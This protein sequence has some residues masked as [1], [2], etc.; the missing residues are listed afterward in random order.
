[1]AAKHG[2]FN[3]TAITDSKLFKELECVG[4][5]NQM[6]EALDLDADPYLFEKMS[7]CYFPGAAVFKLANS[8][9]R[10]QAEVSAY[11]RKAQGEQAW[12]T[13]FNVRRNYSSPFRVDEGLE[14]WGMHHASVVN[15]VRTAKTALMEVFDR[16]T[17]AEWIEQKIYP[18]YKD[19]L[20]LGEKAQK[21][22]ARTTWPARPHEPLPELRALGVGLTDT[23]EAAVQEAAAKQRQQQQQRSSTQYNRSKRNHHEGEF[24]RVQ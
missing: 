24:Y 4:T 14:E 17:T 12:L 8:L 6:E 10:T 23:E 5:H 20:D 16:Y 18:L 21:L 19:L 15:L 1:M 7:W 2:F 13:D 3:A 22:R 11:L 9:E